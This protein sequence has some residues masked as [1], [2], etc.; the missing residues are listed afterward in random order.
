[1]EAPHGDKVN[2]VNDMHVAQTPSAT[3]GPVAVANRLRPVLF[4]LQREI[5]RE[6]HPLGVSAGQV[7][8]LAA[9]RDAPGLPLRAHADRE[10]VSSA[11]M[12]RH[13]DRLEAAGLVTRGRAETG[14]RRR[15]T[16]AITQAG[17]DV[18]ASVR[19]RRTTWLAERLGRLDDVELATI[20]AAIEPLSALLEPDP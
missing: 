15:V 16:I 8:L 12:C 17:L 3:V 9:I 1:M 7:S 10:H 2:Y 4:K 14:D 11:A 19:S 20:A 6:L 5:R 13:V 18:L